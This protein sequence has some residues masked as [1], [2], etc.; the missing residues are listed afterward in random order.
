LPWRYW[1]CDASQLPFQNETFDV[2]LAV[3]SF[4]R[5]DSNAAAMHEIYRTLKP[6]GWFLITTPTH[7]TWLFELGRHGPHYYDLATLESLVLASGLKIEDRRSLGGALYWLL[8][9]VKSWLSR[10]GLRLLGQNWWCVVDRLLLP[11]Y[12]FSLLTDR[13]LPFPPTNWLLIARKAEA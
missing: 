3:E 7:W 11:I 2:A 1:Q 5:I 13:I 9:L 6:G 12:V 10:I 4:E 8:T